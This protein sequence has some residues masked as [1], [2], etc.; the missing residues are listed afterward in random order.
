MRPF[1][2]RH[3]R[4]HRE[5][6]LL[7][8]GTLR[9]RRRICSSSTTRCPRTTKSKMLSLATKTT[10]PSSSTSSRSTSARSAACAPSSS[11]TPCRGRSTTTPRPARAQR[12]GRHRL[13]R[14]QPGPRIDANLESLQNLEDNLKRQGI[15][16]REIPLVI[17][18]NKRDLPNALGIPTSPPK[19][20][21]SRAALR[22]GG[23]DR[24]RCRRNAE[25]RDATRPPAPDQKVRTGRIR[26]ARPRDSD[27]QSDASP[28][29]PVRTIRCG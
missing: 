29:R 25:R 20:T 10:A 3:Q 23:H 16:I 8:P 1:Q 13:R 17:Q 14:R 11:S 19:S 22:V 12:R 27:S 7:R 18:Y 6:R 21:S 5:D 26:A 15:R 4:D 28:P 24:H 2:L 9:Q